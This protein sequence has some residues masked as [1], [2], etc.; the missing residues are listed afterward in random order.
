MLEIEVFKRLQG[1]KVDVYPGVAPLG[2]PVP[3][4]TVTLISVGT[5]WTLA[6]YA[7]DGAASVQVTTWDSDHV[8]ALDLAADLFQSMAGEG[9]GFGTVGAQRLPD[10]YEVEPRRYGVSWEYTI[11][12][13]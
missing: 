8:R 12:S 5:E 11:Q 10:N 4:V 1:H 6:G 2:A 3:Y 9:E 13:I 7:G